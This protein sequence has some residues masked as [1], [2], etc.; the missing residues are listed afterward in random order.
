M[1]SDMSDDR[2]YTTDIIDT[3]VDAIDMIPIQAMW[4][5]YEPIF[6]SMFKTIDLT[7]KCHMILIQII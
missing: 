7:A 2:I 4:S 6:L 1:T 5:I 3:N